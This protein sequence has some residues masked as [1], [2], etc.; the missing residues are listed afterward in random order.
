M[1]GLGK[2]KIDLKLDK[3]QF[4]PGD[5]ITGTITLQLKKPVKAKGVSVQLLGEKKVRQRTGTK[6]HTHTTKIFD[7]SKP[8]DSEKTYATEEK[9]YQF[10]INIPANIAA[11]TKIDSP[12]GTAVKAINMF[13]GASSQIKWHVIARLD[14][15][16]A[17]DVTKKVQINI[18]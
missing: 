13:V 5:I 17:I 8:L 11:E 9:K 14:V 10:K 1:F 6:I 3:L 15:P 7:F 4:R 18:G 12:L 16:W 2:G